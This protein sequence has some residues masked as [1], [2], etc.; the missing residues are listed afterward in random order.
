MS[1][2]T[3]RIAALRYDY[4]AQAKEWPQSC[5]LCGARGHAV[6][7]ASRDRY[8]Y[9]ATFVVCR[10][11]GFGYLCPRLSATQ[12]AHF[13]SDIYR[14]L[15]SAYH[16]RRID[17]ET[18]QL[19]QHGYATELAAFLLPLL[20]SPPQ[21]ILDVGGSTGVVASV[22]ATGLNARATVLDPS[23]D[24]LAVARAAGMETITG[25]VEDFDPGQRRWDLVLLCQTIDHL[26]DVRGTL[27]GLRQMVAAGGRAFVDIVD[28]DVLLR[29]T[30]NIERVIKIDHPYYLTRTTAIALFALTGFTIVA[31]RLSDDG[32]RGFVL[33]PGSPAEPDWPALEATAARF[34]ASIT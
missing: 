10:C 20:P 26:I 1:A 18:V 21:T 30:G 31:E 14:P 25:F 8:G 32:H 7:V 9:P 29:R 27:T 33:A 13:Y 11:C 22:L 34:L 28:V 17:A 5:N 6:E 16:G 3:A 12:Y 4:A 2:L 23:P 24:E 19:E 15:V